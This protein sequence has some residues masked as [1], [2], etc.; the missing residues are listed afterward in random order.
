M[1]TIVVYS[2]YTGKTKGIAEAVAK[3]IGENISC[4]SLDE[5]PTDIASYDCVFF[6][7]YIESGFIDGRSQEVLKTL[8]NKNIA[9]FVTMWIGPYSDDIAKRLRRIVEFLPQGCQIVGTYITPVDDAAGDQQER[10]HRLAADFAANTMH[11]LLST[12]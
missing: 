9:L 8:T 12:T 4:V 1:K 6:G 7:C 11:R 5:I 3:G 2:S 10:E